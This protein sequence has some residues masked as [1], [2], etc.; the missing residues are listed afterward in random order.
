VYNVEELV[1]VLLMSTTTSHLPTADQAFIVARKAA[2][3]KLAADL[4]VA[5]DAR[6]ARMLADIP[7]AD[8]ADF[9]TMMGW[10]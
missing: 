9:I 6:R 8:Q 2:G 10:N 7:V 1:I 5:I 4:T 3:R